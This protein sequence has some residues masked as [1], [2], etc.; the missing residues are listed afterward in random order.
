MC[1]HLETTRS[2]VRNN[3]QPV[4]GG[5]VCAPSELFGHLNVT[6]APQVKH[7]LI[8]SDFRPAVVNVHEGRAGATHDNPMY[9]YH[10]RS[11]KSDLRGDVGV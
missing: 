8:V 3:I 7:W 10:I 1:A 6:L 11:V 9:Y 4:L 2:S 5:Y